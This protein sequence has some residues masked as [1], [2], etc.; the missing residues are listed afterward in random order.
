MIEN[1]FGFVT[2]LVAMIGM[3][4]VGWL[5]RE[6]KSAPPASIQTAPVEASAI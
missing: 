3:L 2:F 6:K 5:L 1:K 4:I